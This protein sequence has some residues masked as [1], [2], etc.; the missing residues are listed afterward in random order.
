MSDGIKVIVIPDEDHH[1]S[2]S[3]KETHHMPDVL[4]WILWRLALAAICAMFVMG[5]AL[6]SQ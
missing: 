2:S 1:K 3:K 6:A 4:T 5:L